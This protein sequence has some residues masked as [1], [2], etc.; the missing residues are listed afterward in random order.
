MVD[1]VMEWL[2]VIKEK[3]GVKSWLEWVGAVRAVT[4]G[5]VCFAS[6]QLVRLLTDLN[7]RSSLKRQEQE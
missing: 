5:K 6:I 1:Q 2:P 4:E 7:A 3:E